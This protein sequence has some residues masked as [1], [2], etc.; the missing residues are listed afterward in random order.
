MAQCWVLLKPGPTTCGTLEPRHACFS[1]YICSARHFPTLLKLTVVL[2]LVPS[3]A[4]SRS[5][6]LSPLVPCRGC[7]R[8]L[9]H[10]R[11]ACQGLLVPLRG[12]KHIRAALPQKERESRR[13][14]LASSVELS[15]SDA[16]CASPVAF[17]ATPLANAFA[18]TRQSRREVVAL[19]WL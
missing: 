13:P 6:A 8:A 9:G 11:Q 16:C 18:G 7:R 4:L 1:C 12:T 2:P 17:S 15:S 19:S 3:D 10:A 5:L 14:G